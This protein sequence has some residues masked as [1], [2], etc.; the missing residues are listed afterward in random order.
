[1]NNYR[2][3]LIFLLL[4]IM[5]AATC[6]CVSNSTNNSKIT[7]DGTPDVTPIENIENVQ[8]VISLE[9]VNEKQDF[10]SNGDIYVY[11]TLKNDMDKELTVWVNVDLYNEKQDVLGTGFD[12]IKLDPNGQSKFEVVVF[13]S[14]EY[15]NEFKTYQS[16]INRVE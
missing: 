4:I 11:G 1:M 16:Y 15:I 2:E 7:T 6:A 14:S 8:N 10:K 5:I 13:N 3:K 12:M 9:I